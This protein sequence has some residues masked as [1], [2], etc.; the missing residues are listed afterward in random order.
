[1]LEATA[2]SNA[3]LRPTGWRR[4][5]AALELPRHQLF[6]VLREP[7]RLRSL[8]YSSVLTALHALVEPDDR[9]FLGEWFGVDDATVRR[10]ERDLCDDTEFIRALELGHRARRGSAITLL[11]A[12][13]SAD[14][15]RCH[16]LLYC[17][18]RLQ[19]PTTVVET[20]VFDG[21]SSAFILKALRDND[22]GHLCSIDL[23]ARTPTR[24]STD[25]M[26]FDTLP[27]GTDPGWVVPDGLRRR[28]TLRL[29]PS[30]DLLAPWLAELGRIDLFFHDSLHTRAHMWWEYERAWSTL[31]AGGVLLSD[32][33]FWSSAFWRFERRVG[34]R[35]RVMRGMG[36][37]RKPAA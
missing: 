32:D 17:A 18:V 10:L 2:R 31:A 15:D 12:V 26:A 30:Q 13:G 27:A 24:S 1:M 28:W 23:A 33:V 25:H 9:H 21:F 14:A 16:R 19:R 5:A 22:H 7:R 34:A 3:H 35:G 36:F 4:F 11:G 29:G 37:L 20:G 8:H 6:R